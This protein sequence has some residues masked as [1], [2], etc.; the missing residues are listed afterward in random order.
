[1]PVTLDVPDIKKLY[2]YSAFV[3]ILHVIQNRSA[4]L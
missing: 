1:M 4:Q 2:T 3:I